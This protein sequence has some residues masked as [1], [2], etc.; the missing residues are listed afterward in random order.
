MWGRDRFYGIPD[1]HGEVDGAVGPDFLSPI[2]KSEYKPNIVDLEIKRMGVR[3]PRQDE[4][5]NPGSKLEKPLRLTDAERYFY[6][7]TVGEEAFKMLETFMKT[8]GY[9]SL[10][11]QSEKGN[12]LVTQR[13]SNNIRGIYNKA[14]ELG[15]AKLFQHKELGPAFIRRIEKIADLEADKKLEELEAIQ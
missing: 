8:S 5:L 15:E 12:R 4:F 10:K 13:L 1:E 7:K 2:Y 3:I 9:K 6:Q 11:E 14:R